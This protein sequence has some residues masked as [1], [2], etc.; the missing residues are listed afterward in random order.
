MQYLLPHII[1]EAAAPYSCFGQ[2]T[3][4]RVG[5]LD[6]HGVREARIGKP[7]RLG[8]WRTRG[9]FIDDMGEQVLQG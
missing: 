7:K 3:G 6:Q 1:D 4:E 2:D 8:V 5:A 9:G